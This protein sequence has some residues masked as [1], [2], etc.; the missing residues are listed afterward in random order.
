MQCELLSP[1]LKEPQV[2]SD[3]DTAWESQRPRGHPPGASG[4]PSPSLSPS[5]HAE[6]WGF[7]DP[8]NHLEDRGL[9]DPK[10]DTAPEPWSLEYPVDSHPKPLGFSDPK[11]DNHLSEHPDTAL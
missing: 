6:P 3:P 11:L 5:T 1:P 8:E 7:S 4:T 10:L 9:E 2:F